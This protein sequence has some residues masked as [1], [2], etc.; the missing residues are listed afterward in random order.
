MHE[1]KNLTRSVKGKHERQE[2]NQIFS[3]V[4]QEVKEQLEAHE[5]YKER[6]THLKKEYLELKKTLN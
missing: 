6:K 4:L 5:E 1:A 2:S 3:S